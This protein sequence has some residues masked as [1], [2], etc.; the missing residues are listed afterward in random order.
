MNN[1]LDQRKIGTAFAA[2][3][4]IGIG[5]YFYQQSADRKEQEGK[6]T[7]YKVQKTFEEEMKAIPVAEQN[8]SK[9]DVDAKFSKTVSELNGILASKTAPA[10]VLFE[11]NVKLGTLYLDHEQ[12]EKAV[13]VF[14]SGSSFA[15]TSLQKASRAYLLGVAFEHSSKFKEA[16]DSFQAG[17]SENAEALKGELL[18]GMVRTSIQ[19]KDLEKAKLFVEK[20]NK[21]LPGSK[22]FDSA[23]ALVKGGK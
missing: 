1:L 19:L 15:S 22:T 5:I 4:L 16:L 8:V 10:R 7:L 18:L 2:L 12:A 9:M 13:G 21:E 11:A 20:I 23:N 3:F 17:L 6:S 14:Q